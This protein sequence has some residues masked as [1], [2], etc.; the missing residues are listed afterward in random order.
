MNRASLEPSPCLGPRA[1]VGPLLD[2]ARI[3]PTTPLPVLYRRGRRTGAVSFGT[4][5]CPAVGPHCGGP[6]LGQPFSGADSQ[7]FVAS[8]CLLL[9]PAVVHLR[10]RAPGHG[11]AHLSPRV[12]PRADV[13]PRFGVV[14]ASPS[15][16]PELCRRGGSFGTVVIGALGFSCFGSHCWGPLMV[17]VSSGADSRW[18]SAEVHKTSWPAAVDG[19]LLWW[20]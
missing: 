12:R 20:H 6:F 3:R 13:G 17:G 16:V 18:H 1:D 8:S 9:G 10:F 15:P 5:A 4:D 2:V 14:R 19:L 11:S 7:T